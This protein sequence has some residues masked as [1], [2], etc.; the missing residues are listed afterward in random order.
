MTA[1]GIRQP[2]YLNGYVF[3]ADPTICNPV[4]SFGETLRR[5]RDGALLDHSH[6]ASII[7]PDFSSKFRFELEWDDLSENDVD[8]WN[9]CI[10]L[11][12]PFLFCPWLTWKESFSFVNGEAIAGTLQRGSAKD[13]IPDALSPGTPATD[14]DVV[15]KLDG[16]VS[17]AFSVGAMVDERTPWESSPAATA[18]PL[19][20]LVVVSYAPLFK[21]RVSDQTP[22]L[23]SARQGGRLV[24]EEY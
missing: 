12:G 6:R 1:P 13:E 8:V 11:R 9:E 20:A 18:T 3:D 14:Y 4:P 23:F 15:F 22:V 24:L 5:A 19:G 10:A 16:T 7:E 2:I 17:T 21:V